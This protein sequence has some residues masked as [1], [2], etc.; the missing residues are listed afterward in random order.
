M[1]GD[2]KPVD[3]HTLPAVLKSCAGLPSLGLGKQVHVT[4]LVNGY[5]SDLANSNA[6]VSMYEKGCDLDSAR[7][8]F[9]RMSNRNE[10]SWS[11]MMSGYGRRGKAY[12]VF[13]LFD[14]ML[15]AGIKVDEVTFTSLLTACSH[16]GQVENGKK[17]FEMMHQR[18]GIKPRLEHYTC[19]VDML[20]RAGLVE[21]AEQVIM[22]MNL[23]ADEALLRTFLLACRTH[24]KMEAAE[25]VANKLNWSAN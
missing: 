9:D 25:R 14:E 1:L 12:E 4:V 5:S 11:A 18:F 3:R 6:L 21:E 15:E 22:G 2:R 20:G 24:G 19:L 7:K 16:S 8:V 17:Y 23:P 10:I 13:H